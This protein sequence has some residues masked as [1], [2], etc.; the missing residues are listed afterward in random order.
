MAL[1]TAAGATAAPRGAIDP[2]NMSVS[3]IDS[4]INDL[5]QPKEVILSTAPGEVTAG[6]G[7][8]FGPGES[9]DGPAS[10]ITPEE[11]ARTGQRIAATLNTVLGFGASM[12]AKSEERKD[13]E[14]DSVDVQQLSKC[15]SDVAMKHSFKIEDS[16]WLNLI[17]LM[18]V[19][20]APIFIRA[21]NDRLEALLRE[22]LKAAAAAQEKVNAKLRAD[23]A[24][25][26]TGE[27]QAA[28]A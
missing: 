12:F 18:A 6:P 8:G 4:L 16:P 15:W 17:I 22:E 1:P 3:D 14:A 27:P 11:A 19:I 13:Y 2:D 20:Y 26:Q 10:T 21:K 9:L 5:N 28:A 25:M 23:I 24:A 7:D